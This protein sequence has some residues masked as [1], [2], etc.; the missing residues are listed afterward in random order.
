MKENNYQYKNMALE[1]DNVLLNINQI[2]PISY[3]GKGKKKKT[4]TKKGKKRPTIE[5]DF[6]YDQTPSTNENI[7]VKKFSGIEKDNFV[8]NNF[9][10]RN[11]INSALF[12]QLSEIKVFLF[13][14]QK[15]MTKKLYKTDK[16]NFQKL[17][18]LN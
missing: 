8:E 15:E 17:I 4:S 7:E 18:M 5:S 11:I 16:R 6:K 13:D 10:I 12:S 14:F 2:N 9:N 3:K 1:T